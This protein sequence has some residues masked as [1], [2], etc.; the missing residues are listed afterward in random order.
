MQRKIIA[1]V[2]AS[3]AHAL[4]TEKARRSPR[5]EKPAHIIEQERLE[6]EKAQRAAEEARLAAEREAERKRLA[7][8]IP[9]DPYAE[10]SSSENGHGCSYAHDRTKK[11]ITTDLNQWIEN[12][13]VWTD[14]DFPVEEAIFWPDVSFEASS[15]VAA[16]ADGVYWRRASEQWPERTLFGADGVT[17]SDTA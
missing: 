1:A 6:A 11:A 13:K 12:G 2:C 8:S 10:V 17:P 3:Y 9:V 15:L 14:K 16:Q 7:E 5:W 4:T